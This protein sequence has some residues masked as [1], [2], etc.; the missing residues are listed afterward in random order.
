MKNFFTREVVSLVLNPALLENSKEIMTV[1]K[2]Q[3]LRG[4]DKSSVSKQ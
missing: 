1:E 4:A 2:P 3:F